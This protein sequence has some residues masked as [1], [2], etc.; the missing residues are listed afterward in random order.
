MVVRD[1]APEVAI[2]KFAETRRSAAMALASRAVPAT[3]TIFSDLQR[4]LG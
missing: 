3:K 2:P 1:R 4:K